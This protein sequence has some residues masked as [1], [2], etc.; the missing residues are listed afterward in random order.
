MH[1]LLMKNIFRLGIKGYTIE[2][3]SNKGLC[4]RKSN[5]FSIKTK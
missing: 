1:T 5:Y 4:L 2:L 3:Q